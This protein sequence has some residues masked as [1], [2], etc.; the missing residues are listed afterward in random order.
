[1]PKVI[2]SNK[3]ISYW[4]IEAKPDIDIPAQ[5]QNANKEWIFGC[6]ICQ[7]VCPWNKKY[8]KTTNINE[9]LNLKNLTLDLNSILNMPQDEFSTK[10][11]NSPIKRT[12]LKGLQRNATA[13]MNTQNN[14]A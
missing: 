8:A 14:K 6:D 13:L 11:K 1:M 5:I 2:D 9:F 4:T 12:K 10:F 7:E 3:C